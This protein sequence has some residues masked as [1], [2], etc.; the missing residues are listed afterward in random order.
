MKQAAGAVSGGDSVVARHDPAGLSNGGLA[1]AL[2]GASAIEAASKAQFLSLLGEFL[3]RQVWEDEGCVSAVQW[4]SWRCGL[5]SVTASEHIRVAQ[6]LR[7]L[8]AIAAALASG[9]VTWSKVR[10]VT[11]VGTPATETTWLDVALDGTAAQVEQIVRTQRRINATDADRQDATHCLSWR[12]ADDDGS[13]VITL[14]VPAAQGAAVI[15]AVAAHTIPEVGV[16]IAAR[17]ADAM[18]ELL[19]GPDIATPTVTIVTTANT[20][21]AGQTEDADGDPGPCATDTGIAIDPGTTAAA[22]CDGPVI[23]ADPRRHLPPTAI[24]DHRHPPPPGPTRPHLPVPRLSPHR[25]PRSPPPHPL[26]TWRITPPRQPR[27]ALPRP[28][29]PHP[30]PEH[31][32]PT[33][34]RR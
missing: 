26:D 32:P 17:R 28:P 33:R 7:R 9:A 34:T 4:L 18:V 5:G 11:R 16:P 8:P 14:R 10:A 22:A 1:A 30:P 15:A 6:A 31:H 13:L 29:P 21:A 24:P 20:L 3:E 2:A 12:Q 23:T 27:P 19:L 25:P